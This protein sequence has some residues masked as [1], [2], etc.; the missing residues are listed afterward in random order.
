MTLSDT[1]GNS[2]PGHD[3]ITCRRVISYWFPCPKRDMSDVILLMSRSSDTPRELTQ[4]ELDRLVEDG[5]DSH[6]Q[7]YLA[8]TDHAITKSL[9]EKYRDV[10]PASRAEAV[11]ALPVQFEGREQFEQSLADAGGQPGEEARVLGYSRFDAERAHVATDHLE[12][13]KTVAHERLHQLSNPRAVDGLGRPLYEGVT[14][15][16]AIDTIGTESP[17]DMERCYPTERAIAHEM[18][19][20]AGSDAVERAYFTGDTTELRK[21]LDEQLGSGG[22]ERLQ[23]QIAELTKD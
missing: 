22:L 3:C 4:V 20:M 1:Q 21:R 12:I 18:R 16:L 14:E 11:L 8:E 7:K 17:R 9:V 10:V 19:D 13:P 23:R 2:P 6:I 15:D 5:Q